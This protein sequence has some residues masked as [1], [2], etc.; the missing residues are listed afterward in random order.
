M[1]SLSIFGISLVSISKPEKVM[2]FCFIL[3]FFFLTECEKTWHGINCSQRCA[4]HCKDNDTCDHVTGQCAGGCD[5]G[6][7]GSLC[8]RGT[9]FISCGIYLKQ[10][11]CQLVKK[12]HQDFCQLKLRKRMLWC[13]CLKSFKTNFW[14]K[15]SLKTCWF[16]K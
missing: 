7:T 1:I 16:W 15:Q 10:Q 9:I 2:T 13:Y 8:N 14:L 3:G 6:W 5:A 11:G 4:G 12:K